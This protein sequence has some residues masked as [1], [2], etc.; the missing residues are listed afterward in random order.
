MSEP[1][2]PEIPAAIRERTLARFEEHRRVWSRNPALRMSYQRWYCRLRKALPARDL[3][4]C[5]EIGSGPGFAREFIPELALTDVVQAPW[6]ERRV[7]AEA[8][9]FDKG[10]VGA[11][12]LFDVLHHLA[13]PAR[14]FTEAAR[15]L[16]PGGRIL[17]VDPYISPV[18]RWVYRLFHPEPVDMSIDPLA[19]AANVALEAKDPFLSNQAT[20]TLMFCR[21][22]RRH[23]AT[24]FPELAVVK[25]ERFAG[26]AYPAT[27]GFS[28]APLLPYWLWRALFAIENLMPEFVFRWFGFR[29][30]VIIE[31]R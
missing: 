31:R 28:R 10:G 26:L 7:F 29:M 14:F 23:F 27:G 19:T 13:A 30:L 18:S 5:I 2:P 12:L 11:L 21:A 24:M 9:P 3:G 15:V 22:G 25:V 8:L 4:P 16:R 20:P 6:H 1:A 17:L